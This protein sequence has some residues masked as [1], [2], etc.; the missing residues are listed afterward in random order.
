MK[1][2]IIYPWFLEKRVHY[3]EDVLAVPMGAYYVAAMLRANGYDVEIINTLVLSNGPEEIERILLEKKPDVAAFTVLHQNRFGAIDIAETAKRL[4]PGVIT[5]FGGIGATNLSGLLL[6]NYDSIDYIARG[7]GE[8][9]FLELIRFIE[10]K[11]SGIRNDLPGHIKGLSYRNG[12]SVIQNQKGG[13]VEEL[14]ALPD[15]ARYFTFNH[16][17]LT[18]GCPGKCAFC[19]SPDFWQGRVRFHSP[20]Y[21]VDQLSRLYEKGVRFFYVSDDMFTVRPELVKTVCRMIMARKI[22]I[23]WAAISHVRYVDEEMLYLMRLAGCIQISFGVESGSSVILEKLNKRHTAKEVKRAFDLARK[24]G[25]MARAYYIYGCPGE[26]EHTIGES[27]ALLDTTKP[28]AA[29]FYVLDIFPGT[30]LYEDFKKRKGVTDDIWLKRVEDILYYETDP[31]LTQDM[32]LG[33]GKR[34]RNHFYGNL[35]AYCRFPEWE[36]DA[37]IEALNAMRSDFLSRLAMTLTHGDYAR[38]SSVSGKEETA[39]A[40]YEKALSLHPDYRA[41][42]GLGIHHQKK[43]DFKKSIGILEEGVRRYP[44]YEPLSICLGVSLMNTGKMREAADI[45]RRF[46]ESPDAARFLDVCGK[47]TG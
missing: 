6:N 47:E 32:V 35:T 2:L 7:E 16:V 3:E 30:A 46:P 38:V 31:D 27:I 5:V 41:Y 23:N 9:A 26:S 19:G 12:D 20:E 10:Q 18:R 43:R 28:Q 17:S 40:L 29:L 13:F 42:L 21:F 37:A 33:F 34:L 1:I 39:R 4:I 11:K 45:F 25:I 14:D 15:P 24:Y 22:A 8:T 44:Y 36:K